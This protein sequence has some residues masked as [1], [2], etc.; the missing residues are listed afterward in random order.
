MRRFTNKDG[1][2]KR[3]VVKKLPY[4]KRGRPLLLGDYLDGQLRAYTQKFVKWAWL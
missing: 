4:K 3:N 2:G 1:R